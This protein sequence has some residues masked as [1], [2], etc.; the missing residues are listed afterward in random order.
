MSKN[1]Y[2]VVISALALGGA[3]IEHN[4][5]ASQRLV[6]DESRKGMLAHIASAQSTVV[7]M[8]IERRVLW[9]TNAAPSGQIG[10]NCRREGPQKRLS[11]V[12]CTSYIK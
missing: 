2:D 7:I 3:A 8:R 10:L 4:R 5:R 9:S 1:A 12:P 6:K 11:A